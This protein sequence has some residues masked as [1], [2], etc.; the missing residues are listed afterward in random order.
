MGFQYIFEEKSAY[1]SSFKCFPTFLSKFCQ[2]YHSKSGISSYFLEKNLLFWSSR[3][4]QK[5]F[6]LYL[7][8]IYFVLVLASKQT[9]FLSLITFLLCFSLNYKVGTLFSFILFGI[10]HL[11]NSHQTFQNFIF[12]QTYFYWSFPLT[13]FFPSL[14]M[15][16]RKKWAFYQKEF[17][18][19]H[20][21]V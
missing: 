18:W 15:I 2:S 5:H 6:S 14:V 21:F 9:S 16:S 8:T 4:N 19:P 20:I 17:T 12:F 10:F 1:L 3:P 11:L 7:L 13:I